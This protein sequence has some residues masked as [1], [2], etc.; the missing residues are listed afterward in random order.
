MLVSEQENIIRVSG[1]QVFSCFQQQVK[2]PH[3]LF[4]PRD[5]YRVL[6]KAQIMLAASTTS[7]ARQDL[8]YVLSVLC[9]CVQ[10]HRSSSSLSIFSSICFF[11]FFFFW[12]KTWQIRKDMRGYKQRERNY[13]LRSS[14]ST[15][16][17]YILLVPNL[18]IYFCLI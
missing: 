8:F 17:R 4:F 9:C 3:D 1:D 14:T 16:F 5:I 2:L 6:R 12:L 13:N 10:S 7:G 18:L 15:I 11:F